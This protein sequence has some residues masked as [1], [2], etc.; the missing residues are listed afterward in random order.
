M[1]GVLLKAK[2]LVEEASPDKKVSEKQRNHIWTRYCEIILEGLEENPEPPSPP[3]GKR[4]RVKRSKPLNLLIRL[5]NRVEEIMGFF[6]YDNVPYDNNQ[7]ERDLRMMKVREKISGT[8]RAE[9]HA[10][11]FCDIRGIILSARKQSRAILGTLA[12]LIESPTQLGK[13]LANGK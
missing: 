7:A 2:H 3:A 12:A 13:K 10:E 9:D 6:E 5:E 11:A 4:G 1:I 8:F